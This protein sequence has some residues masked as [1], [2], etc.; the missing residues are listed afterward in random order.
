ME[1][2]IT[3]QPLL[4]PEGRIPPQAVDL[5]EGVLGAF[6]V[7]TDT[8]DLIP[9]VRPEI[10]YVE[11]NQ[12]IM[13][14]IKRLHGKHKPVDIL[15]VT[16]ELRSSGDLEFAGGP[17]RITVL[18]NAVASGAHI[19]YHLKIV[20]QKY[21]GRT[22]IQVSSELIRSAYDDTE[23]VFDIMDKAEKQ[24]FASK[25]AVSANVEIKTMTDVTT[26]IANMDKPVDSIDIAFSD[27][28]KFHTATPGDLIVVAGRPGMGKSS[29]ALWEARKTCEQ[30]YPVAYFSL[31]MFARSLVSRLA[32]TSGIPYYY[33][34]NGTVNAENQQRL[35]RELSNLQELEMYFIDNRYMTMQNIIST[36][37]RLVRRN[38]VKRIYIDQ[39]S[40]VRMLEREYR[41]EY[42]RSTE[43][44]RLCKIMA[45]DLNVPVTLLTQISRAAESR[46]GDK[47]PQLSDLKSTGAI[48][49]FAD[50]VGL[51]WRPEYYNTAGKFDRVLNH[52]GREISSRG[53]VELNWA[54]Q[55]NGAP[56]VV[57]LSFDAPSFSFDRFK[58]REYDRSL[59][60]IEDIPW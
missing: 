40:L 25:E 18:S 52:S 26:E 32:T 14:A 58:E 17:Y 44:C 22:L 9:D 27:I 34:N 2:R 46:G 20:E 36:S 37:R 1:K 48:E 53:Y 10:F 57:E 11:A 15:T 54:K 35:F 24:L 38:G 6:L 56:G 21:L 12:K 41:D 3:T 5:E 31:E 23:D 47:R 16:E 49:E 33:I 19:G 42:P 50:S 4:L 45:G 51:L 43:I 28:D 13:S 29:Y 30:G 55:R 8:H 39:L 60:K 59:G 7:D